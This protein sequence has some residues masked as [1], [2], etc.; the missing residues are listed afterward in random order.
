M[1]YA[2]DELLNLIITL[3]QKQKN[4]PPSQLSSHPSTDDRIDHL[5]KPIG[6]NQYNRYAYAGVGEHAEIKAKVKK[7]LVEQKQQGEKN[8]TDQ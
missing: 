8:V 4:N 2:A 1:G 3:G 5:E 7:L 6:R